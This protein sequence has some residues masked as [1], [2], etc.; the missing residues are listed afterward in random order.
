[1]EN[2]YAFSVERREP[3]LYLLMDLLSG[4]G[5]DRLRIFHEQQSSSLILE[6]SSVSIKADLL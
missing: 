4:S 1:M 6:M 3:E 2:S 5:M